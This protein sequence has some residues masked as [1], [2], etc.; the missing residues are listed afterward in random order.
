M[1]NLQLQELLAYF[2]EVLGSRG[3]EEGGCG[4]VG[5]AASSLIHGNY[6]L[7]LNVV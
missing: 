7:K 1:K 5:T 3:R 6:L 2:H 4:W